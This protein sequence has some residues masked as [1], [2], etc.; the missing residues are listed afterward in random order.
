M[1]LSTALFSLLFTL[2]TV[3]SFAQAA[4]CEGL[5]RSVIAAATNGKSDP[6]LESAV[7]GYAD[8]VS[9]GT[10][11]KFERLVFTTGASEIV[12]D[13]LPSY[14]SAGKCELKSL[15]ITRE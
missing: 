9:T 3:P 2:L 6:K 11:I 5:A 10:S 4:E 8:E 7:Q 13:A 1:R 14:Y 12:V 15:N